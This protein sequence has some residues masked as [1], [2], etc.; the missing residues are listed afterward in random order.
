MHDIQSIAM[1]S[2]ILTK[3]S[4][5]QIARLLILA[6]CLGMITDAR[7]ANDYWA[8]MPGTTATTNWTDSAN[9]TYSGQSSPQTYYNQVE[10]LGV[11]AS[12]NTSVAVNNVLD[13][14]TGIA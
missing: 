10:F 11:G 5:L 7:A 3:L 13:A 1:K 12:A 4:P 6:L 2:T 9:W 14:T 8:G